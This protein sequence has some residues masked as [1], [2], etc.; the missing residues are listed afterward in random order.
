M[1]RFDPHP[2]RCAARFPPQ[3]HPSTPSLRAFQQDWQQT[4]A[5]MWV[6]VYLYGYSNFTPHSLR[7]SLKH[8][9]CLGH[10]A[11]LRTLWPVH[12][13]GGEKIGGRS[14]VPS[15]GL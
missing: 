13:L 5:D 7:E 11:R 2:G 12:P 10:L 6:I 1:R 14:V 4:T 3:D 8:A 15:E 9:R